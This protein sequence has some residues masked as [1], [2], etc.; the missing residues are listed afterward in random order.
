MKRPLGRPKEAWML[1]FIITFFQKLFGWPP[2]PVG[3]GDPCSAP[4]CVSAR[5]RLRAARRGFDG[6]CRGL[7]L[8][9]TVTDAL[10]RILNPVTVIGLIVALVAL[11]LLSQIPVLRPLAI[12][13]GLMVLG[14]L[15]AFLFLPVL[16]EIALQLTKSLADS[17]SQVEQALRDV[18]THCPAE[19]RG[20]VSPPECKL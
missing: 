1:A 18:V 16:G 7:R 9:R 6:A 8:T 13:L 3:D 5:E 15:L 2:A 10:V 12:L 14:V 4:A 11:I 19:C 20:D 17:R